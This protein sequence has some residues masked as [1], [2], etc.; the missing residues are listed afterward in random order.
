VSEACGDLCTL[1]LAD[2]TTFSGRSFGARGEAFGEVVFCT[3]ITGYQEILTDPSYC[4][5]IVTMTAPEIGNVGVN[6][7]DVE[8]SRPWCA[9]LIVRRRSASVSNWRAKE[10]LGDYLARHRVVGLWDIDTRALTRHIRTVGAQTGVL[11]TECHDREELVRRA[12]AAPTLVG[13]DLAREV[14]CREPYSWNAPSHAIA[15]GSAP[16]PERFHVVAYDF[17]IKHN[18]L[19]RLRDVGC[20]TTVVPATFAAREAL[21]LKPDGVFLSN[22]PGDPAA[23]TYGVETIRELCA[24]RKP[25]FGI[26]LGHQ[27]LGLALGAK[28][29]KLKFGHR[30]ANQPVM[31]LDTRRVEITS[32]N[33]GFAVDLD[34]LAGKARLT[35]V[36]LND[37]TV[38]GLAIDGRPVFSVQ[39]HPEASP[40][41]HDAAYLF[42]RFAAAMSAR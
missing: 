12:R 39:Y 2:G 37:R 38:E 18:I 28:T 1:A 21:A 42:D 5:Q 32:H 35:H 7:D 4:G 34:S 20:R 15:H 19:R 14:T 41:P 17:G 25:V 9:A 3:S 30:G 13:R 6:P 16:P 36:N 11:S 10:G 24:S 33:H 40:G 27:M 22:G 8:S 31:D 23:V 26:C 29:Y